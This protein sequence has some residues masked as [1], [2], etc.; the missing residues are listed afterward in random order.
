MESVEA[1]DEQADGSE[2]WTAAAGG[3]GQPWSPEHSQKVW[4]VTALLDV[5]G[6]ASRV[7]WA[8]A[9]LSGL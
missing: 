7:V 1:E 6:G 4:R 8:R 3:C 5:K 2:G 9:Q